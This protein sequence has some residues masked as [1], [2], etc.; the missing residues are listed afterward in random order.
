MTFY[1]DDVEVRALLRSFM[2]LALLPV[3]EISNGFNVLKQKVTQ[4]HAA[5]QL[6]PFVTYF[7][8]EW[9]GTFKP[10]SWSVSSSTWRTNNFAE[11]KISFDIESSC[12]EM[13]AR[14]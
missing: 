1:D 14:Y 3:D 6:E 13:Y 7:E 4:C 9:L 2:A 12:V 5:R 10:S 11:G 8:D